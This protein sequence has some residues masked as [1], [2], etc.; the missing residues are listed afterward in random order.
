MFDLNLFVFAKR[1]TEVTQERI[2][3]CFVLGGCRDGNCKTKDILCI[4]VGSLGEYCMLFD[5]DSDVTHLVDGCRLDTAEVLYARKHDVHELVE[6][7]LHARTTEGYLVAREVAGAHLECCD[8]LLAAA[9]CRSLA[10]DFDETIMDEVGALLVFHRS[11]ADRDHELD[12]LWSLHDVGVA[13]LALERLECFLLL[14]YFV[15]TGI[16]VLFQCLATFDR[17]A[18]TGTVFTLYAYSRRLIGLWIDEH[19]IGC[20]YRHYLLDDLAST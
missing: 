20:V 14:S 4:F 13:K 8:G 19:D 17:N 1:H 16:Y 9:S 5:T 6:E 3:F 11:N 18:R 10:R 12:E 7:C 2:C 15:H